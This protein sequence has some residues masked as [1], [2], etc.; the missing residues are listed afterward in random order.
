MQLPPAG[1]RT[2]QQLLPLTHPHASHPHAA[3]PPPHSGSQRPAPCAPAA[4]ACP[5]TP[6]AL[7]PGRPGRAGPG[8]SGPGASAPAAP[9]PAPAAPDVCGRPCPGRSGR[10]GGR[11]SFADVVRGLGAA[12]RCHSDAPRR[13]A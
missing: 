13:L 1:T 6:C 9:A 11:I 3:P 5:Y 8:R 12:R 4:P 2:Q 7:R 10:A